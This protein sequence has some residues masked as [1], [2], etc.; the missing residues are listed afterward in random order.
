[1][2]KEKAGMGGTP[3]LPLT[4]AEREEG[5]RR[6]VRGREKQSERERKK[7]RQAWR[8]VKDLVGWPRLP[9]SCLIFDK[10]STKKRLIFTESSSV[11]ARG[12]EGMGKE[13]V[14]EEN[15]VGETTGGD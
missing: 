10:F 12:E 6:V 9:C 8:K 3:F 4:R 5:T 2:V 7:R 1:M 11:E 14:G 15:E 13:G